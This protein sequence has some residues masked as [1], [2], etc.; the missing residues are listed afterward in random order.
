MSYR[1][2]LKRKWKTYAWHLSNQPNSAI[3]NDECHAWIRKYTCVIRIDFRPMLCSWQTKYQTLDVVENGS[4]N[5]TTMSNGAYQRF[6]YPPR[7]LAS[8]NSGDHWPTFSNTGG[9][10]PG[11]GD[12]VEDRK[13]RGTTPHDDNVDISPVTLTEVFCSC[14]RTDLVDGVDIITVTRLWWQFA[15]IFHNTHLHGGQWSTSPRTITLWRPLLPYGYS[16]YL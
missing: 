3:T 8:S 16:L 12:C 4:H 7:S 10:E 14:K 11:S 5:D 13:T 1:T 2:Q 6:S 15:R 9:V